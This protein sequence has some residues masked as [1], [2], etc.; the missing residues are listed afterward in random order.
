M[1][2]PDSKYRLKA[3]RLTDNELV[4]QGNV[5]RTGLSFMVV[6]E[7][8]QFRNMFKTREQKKKKPTKG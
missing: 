3:F 4:F 2:T 1:L 7:F 8:N 6:L 5:V